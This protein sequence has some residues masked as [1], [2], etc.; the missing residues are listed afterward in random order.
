MEMQKFVWSF[1]YGEPKGVFDCVAQK[2]NGY[3]ATKNCSIAMNVACVHNDDKTVWMVTDEKYSW[4]DVKGRGESVCGDK[5]FVFG[6]PTDGYQN[7][8]LSVESLARYV[9]VNTNTNEFDNYRMDNRITL[10]F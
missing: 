5:D 2:P 7:A 3:W 8:L 4:N 1:A 9:W 10:K 6:V